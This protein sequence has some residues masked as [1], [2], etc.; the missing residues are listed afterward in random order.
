MAG[1]QIAAALEALI[2]AMGF[3]GGHQRQPRRRRTQRD[4]TMLQCYYCQQLGHSARGCKNAV[5][6]LKCAAALDTRSCTKP[7]GVACVCANCGGPHAAN[8]RS[9]GYLRESRRLPAAPRPAATSSASTA[10]PPP[11]FSEGCEPRRLEATTDEAMAGFQAR[12]CASPA[13]AAARRAAGYQEAAA[14]SRRQ[15]RR[16]SSDGGRRG[17]ANHRSPSCSNAGGGAH[18]NR[19][20]AARAAP[21]QGGSHKQGC[22]RAT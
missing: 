4:R 10:A 19:G 16:E 1:K 17:H 12:S 5:A 8:S 18:G 9:C 7:R 2:H 15:P 6:C 20:I 14:R 22:R 21:L 3:T 11:R 13:P